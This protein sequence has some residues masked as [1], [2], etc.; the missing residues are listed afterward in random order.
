MLPWWP[1]LGIPFCSF[2]MM[3]V[4]DAC[5]HYKIPGPSTKWK[6]SNVSDKFLIIK[7]TTKRTRMLC[8]CFVSVVVVN[9]MRLLL[10]R[11]SVKIAASQQV[12]N[13]TQ[14]K[15]RFEK[16]MISNADPS[17]I[18]MWFMTNQKQFR[19]DYLQFLLLLKPADAGVKISVWDK[20]Y[21]LIF[22]FGW[23]SYYEWVMCG[24]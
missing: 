17:S 24:V 7:Y 23:Q 21:A 9:N 20:W 14:K 2:C 22:A 13:M 10:I 3:R 11:S 4:R 16:K 12:Y 1:L 8:V 19:G 6:R 18:T 15:Q 5:H